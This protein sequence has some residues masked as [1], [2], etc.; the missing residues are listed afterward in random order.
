MYIADFYI[1][2]PST[3]HQKMPTPINVLFFIAHFNFKANSFKSL[4]TAI[5]EHTE[6]TLQVPDI[7]SYRNQILYKLLA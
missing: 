5:P 7:S 1:L 2:K 6:Q 3:A 4:I